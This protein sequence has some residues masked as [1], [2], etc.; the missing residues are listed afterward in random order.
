[1]IFAI[2]SPSVFSI[3]QKNLPCGF[4]IGLSFVESDVESNCIEMP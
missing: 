3:L 2:G 4:P 1:M